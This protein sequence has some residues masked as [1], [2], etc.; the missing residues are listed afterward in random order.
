MQTPGQSR[1]TKAVAIWLYIGVFM[2]M[3]QVILGGITRLTGSGLSITEWNV[4]KGS[5]PPLTEGRWI[6]EFEKY[7]ATP[8]F[9][10]L[11]MDFTL[12]D[13]KFIYFWEWLHRNWARLIGIVFVA[14]FIYLVARKHLR[15]DMYGPLLIL[16]PLG[17]LLGAVG[18]IMVVSGLSGDAIY[19]RPTRLALHFV[20]AIGVICYTFWLALQSSVPATQRVS[21]PKIKNRV[22]A[23]LVVLFFQLIYGALMAGHKAATAAPTW[24]DINGNFVPPNILSE[25]PLM[26]NFVENTQT[27]H[28]IHR[29]L[30]YLLLVLIIELLIKISR[31]TNATPYLKK[32]AIFPLIFV[33]VQALL[34]II[35]VIISPGIIPGK[36]GAFEWIAQL[37]QITG[38]LLV[39]SMIVPWYLTTGKS[40]KQSP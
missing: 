29:M 9:R 31:N 10:L 36:W 1:S 39:L 32:A 5:M 33:I 6:Q 18:W 28:F 27:I 17:A 20:Y 21:V 15:K 22:L 34:G 12:S 7:K 8:Q 23:I 4:V 19:V 2:L 24:P 40:F 3:I 11:N 14:G 13:F 25:T 37:H 30:A 38:M 35:S 26:L 16:L